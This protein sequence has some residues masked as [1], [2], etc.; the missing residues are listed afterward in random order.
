M[1]TEPTR[2]FLWVLF[3]VD[4][5]WENT[6]RTDTPSIQGPT[7]ELVSA[8]KVGDAAVSRIGRDTTGELLAANGTT[9]SKIYG[10]PSSSALFHR[11]VPFLICNDSSREGERE[12]RNSVE[13][14]RGFLLPLGIKTQN[15]LEMHQ[16]VACS[17]SRCFFPSDSTVKCGSV[18]TDFVCPACDELFLVLRHFLCNFFLALKIVPPWDRVWKK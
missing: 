11:K 14:G 18:H 16:K 8:R 3:L 5:C 4:F 6:G 15:F 17:S 2:P 1:E 7:L 10:P 12:K 13:I 9:S